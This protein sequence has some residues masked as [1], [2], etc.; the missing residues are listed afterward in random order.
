MIFKDRR[1][2]ANKLLALLKKDLQL[3][4]T[5]PIIISLLR[6]GV[7]LG[8]LIAT[9]LKTQHLPLAVVKIPAPAN[10]ELAIGAICFD[11]TYLENKVIAWLNLPKRAVTD[12]IKVAQHKFLEYC[13][14][15]GL[16]ENSYRKLTNKV[17]VLVDDGIATG[18]SVKAALLFLRSRGVAKIILA[19]PVGP[20]D[21]DFFGFDKTYFLHQPAS[22]GAVSQF[23]KHFPQITDQE[24]K[25]LLLT[26]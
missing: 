2:A 9:K 18:A 17:V 14:R 20:A 4:Q 23:Y 3:K 24:V 25:R 5:K 13:Q 21:T 16:Q 19:A 15:F 1:Q 8:S 22:F 11:I 26:N 6:G 12:Q 7:V 10:P